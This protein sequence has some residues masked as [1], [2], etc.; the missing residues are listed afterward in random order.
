VLTF[1]GTY[2]PLTS[3]NCCT[4]YSIVLTFVLLALV[5]AFRPQGLFGRAG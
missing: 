4:Q 2:L 3:N 1:S 5:L